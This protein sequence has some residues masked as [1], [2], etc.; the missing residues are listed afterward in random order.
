[1]PLDQFLFANFTEGSRKALSLARKQAILWGSEFVGTEH[2]LMGII[3]LG[4]LQPD[5][6]S[7]K[8]LESLNLDARRIREEIEKIVS[9]SSAGTFSEGQLPFSPRAGE[10]VTAAG[11]FSRQFYEESV[12]PEHVLLGVTWVSEGIA[13]QV[14][15]RL[16]IGIDA[17]GK[18]L[19]EL[20]RNKDASSP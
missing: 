17:L 6:L 18:K 12:G 13:A 7:R 2:L 15:T 4:M 19:V 10:A 5:C 8:M 16:G 1:M 20:K 11:E 3:Q 9:K 14:L